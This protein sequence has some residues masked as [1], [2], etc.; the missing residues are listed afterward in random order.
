MPAHHPLAPPAVDNGKR[1]FHP[2]PRPR[3]AFPHGVETCFPETRPQLVK[4]STKNPYP[5]PRALQR[6]GRVVEI[7]YRC[8][9]LPATVF[10]DRQLLQVSARNP[11]RGLALLEEV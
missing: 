1:N 8:Q 4:R 9:C 5:T 10:D 7:R 11:D 2:L 3:P 6:H